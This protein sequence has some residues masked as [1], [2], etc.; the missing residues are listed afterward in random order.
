MAPRR[1]LINH[2]AAKATCNGGSWATGALAAG[3]D[4][5]SSISP[6]AD[7]P[8][9]NLAVARSR[10]AAQATTAALAASSARPALNGLDQIDAASSATEEAAAIADPTCR[11][12]CA[13]SDGCSTVQGTSTLYPLEHQCAVRAAEAERIF[14]RDVDAHLARGVGAVVQI[15]LGILIDEVDRRR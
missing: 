6:V 5:R 10:P 14:Q 12:R 7:T 11:Q 2:G 15:A 8:I 9:S 1:K 4:S 3:S 13:R